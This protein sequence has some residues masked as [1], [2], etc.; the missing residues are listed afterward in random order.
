MD[1]D[2]CEE[3]NVHDKFFVEAF[4]AERRPVAP[5]L[6]SNSK[7]NVNRSKCSIAAFVATDS[8]PKTI[9]N[10]N[11]AAMDANGLEGSPA[12]HGPVDSSAV[13]TTATAAMAGRS[14]GT[15]P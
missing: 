1:V 2:S 7:R 11:P 12:F 6:A 15:T 13:T 4:L 9:P 14:P 5:E 10:A 3:R 8:P